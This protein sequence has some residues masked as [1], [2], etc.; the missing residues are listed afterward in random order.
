MQILT[1]PP[2]HYALHSV[3]LAQMHQLHATVFRSLLEWDVIITSCGKFD[4]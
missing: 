3:E 1:V 4:D 2:D